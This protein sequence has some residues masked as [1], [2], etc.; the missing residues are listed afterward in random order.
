[1]E[2]AEGYRTWDIRKRKK[3]EYMMKLV[4]MTVLGAVAKK[5][6][7]SSPAIFKERQANGGKKKRAEGKQ[8]AKKRTKKKKSIQD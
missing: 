1:M 2:E 7:G 6:A 5:C 8:T 4:D 3:E